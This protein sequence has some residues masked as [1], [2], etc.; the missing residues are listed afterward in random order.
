M[1][2]R[3]QQLRGIWARSGSAV[4]Q[5]IF[6]DAHAG[7]V[8]ELNAKR[9]AD[10]AAAQVV[11]VLDD[12]PQA[13]RAVPVVI[14]SSVPFVQHD[15]ARMAGAVMDPASGL[16]HAPADADLT[17]LAQCLTHAMP[18]RPAA[19]MTTDAG[20]EALAEALRQNKLMQVQMAQLV[21]RV[22]GK[23]VIDAGPSSVPL[24]AGIPLTDPLAPASQISAAES[25]SLDGAV[26]AVDGAQ[27][28]LVTA[29]PEMQAVTHGTSDRVGSHILMCV[30]YTLMAL[31]T[32]SLRISASSAAAATRLRSRAWSS[33]N[34]RFP[35]RRRGASNSAFR[36]ILYLSPEPS[37]QPWIS[38]IS[39]HWRKNVI[40]FLSPS[41]LR[42]DLSKRRTFWASKLP[43]FFHN[44]FAMRCANSASRDADDDNDDCILSKTTCS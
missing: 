25:R 9:M 16:W 40:S 33:S 22:S 19:E 3:L 18:V 39:G 12:T 20:A 7:W 42:K 28:P 2:T 34:L 1:L 35:D 30:R 21:E 41:S 11:A 24:I 17:S 14:S 8:G 44:S 26:A 10:R 43:P 23:E 4:D 6:I 29:L 38:N 5:Q 31:Q 36:F 32:I 27:V 15:A 13:E 37:L